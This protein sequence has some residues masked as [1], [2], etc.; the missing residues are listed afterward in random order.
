[1]CCNLVVL[2]TDETTGCCQLSRIPVGIAK[3]AFILILLYLFI[4]SLDLLGSA[5]QL[6]GGKAAGK[7]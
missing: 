2:L 6:L 4:C 5:F 7:P 3:L 1:M